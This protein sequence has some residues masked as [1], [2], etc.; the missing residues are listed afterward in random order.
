MILRQFRSNWTATAARRVSP[1]GESK[2]HVPNETRERKGTMGKVV[3]CNWVHP[4]GCDLEIRAKLSRR[5]LNRQGL[6]PLST[7]SSRPRNFSGW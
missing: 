3:C 7:A 5:C 1:Q 6:M 2:M 4:A